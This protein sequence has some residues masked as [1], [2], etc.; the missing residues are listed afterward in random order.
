MGMVMNQEKRIARSSSFE[1]MRIMA[2][3]MVVMGHCLM[4]TGLH[5]TEPLSACDN[6]AWLLS[7]FGICAVNLFF[8][9]TGYFL[10]G[11][12]NR[13]SKIISLWGKTVFISI[14][15]YL[16]TCITGIAEFGKKEFIQ[17]LFPVLFK[18]YWFIQ[19]YIVLALLL[20]F[21]SKLMRILSGRQHFALTVILITF[22]SVH[23][24]FI[25]VNYT[26]DT[27]QGYGII[28]GVVL[29]ITGSL[30]KR[31]ADKIKKMIPIGM[32]LGGYIFVAIGIFITNWLIVKFNVAQGITSRGNFYAYNS[33][34]VFLEAILLFLF[35][36]KMEDRIG[37]NKVINQIGPSILT[38]YLISAH[39]VLLIYLWTDIFKLN[40]VIEKSLWLYLLEMFVLTGGVLA[41][42]VIMDK[43]IG[44]LGKLLR[45]NQ[46]ISKVDKLQIWD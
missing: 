29:V 34:S 25:P 5:N 11:R 40:G 30:I 42:C 15:V 4:A 21:I 36:V 22:F 33:I 10:D 2:M 12:N 18:R 28:W 45:I 24:T 23:Q 37:S 17:F 39:P 46:T 41:V 35:F 19:T 27:T 44:R 38:V 9:L 14:S 8:L 6:A 31:S 32:C 26:L 20:P 13:L 3:F 16:I 1:I 7:S 43:A